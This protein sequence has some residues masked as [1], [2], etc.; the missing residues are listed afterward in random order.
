M[1]EDPEGIWR[2]VAR[3]E[4]AIFSS[5]EEIADLIPEICR[6]L[7][8]RAPGGFQSECLVEKLEDRHGSEKLLEIRESLK[9]DRHNSPYFR[10]V[11]ADFSNLKREGSTEK[12]LRDDWQ[13]RRGCQPCYYFY[14]TSCL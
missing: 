4:R 7:H 3:Q 12:N 10:G 5:H 11:L 14:A 9:N 2:E 6:D 13:G 8:T 1:G